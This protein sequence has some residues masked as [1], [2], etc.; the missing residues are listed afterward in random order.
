MKKLI[1]IAFGAVAAT[2]ALAQIDGYKVEQLWNNN[3]GQFSSGGTFPTLTMTSANQSNTTQNDFGDR[4]VGWLSADGGAS[5]ALIRGRQDFSLFFTI[6]MTTDANAT[7]PLEGGLLMKYDNHRGFTP[8]SQFYAKFDPQGTPGPNIQTSADWVLPGYDFVA[9]HGASIGD[10]QTMLMGIE[11]D[12]NEGNPMQSMQRLTFGN[13]QSPW[14]NGNWGGPIYD[15]TMQLG[16][17]FQ[18]LVEGDNSTHTS[19][20]TFNLVSFQGGVVPEPG[21]IA[22]LA[23]G[24]LFLLRR[25]KK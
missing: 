1:L 3:T 10:N 21:T 17:Y 20:A 23:V 16:F 14:M 8:E 6:N 7:R 12:Y 15:E 18:P 5:A 9:E 2:S 13:F 11:Y 4:Y 24:G 22:A 19:T 25:R